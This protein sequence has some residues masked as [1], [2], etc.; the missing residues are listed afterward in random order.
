MGM[1][2]LHN[3]V[4]ATVALHTTAISSS[5]TTA[6]VIIDRAGFR[7]LEFAILAGTLTDGTYTPKIEEGDESDLSDAATVDASDLLGTIADATLAATDDNKVKRIGYKG[8]KRYV[9]LSETSASV[10][11]GGTISAVALLGGPYSAPVA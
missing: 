2:D 8:S 5:T 11:T 3:N 1:R 7:S 10:S 4:S 9:R 6:G